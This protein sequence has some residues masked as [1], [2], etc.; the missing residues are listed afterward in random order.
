MVSRKIVFKIKRFLPKKVFDFLLL[1]KHVPKNIGSA[2]LEL[3]YRFLNRFF[4][5]YGLSKRERKTKIILSTTTFPKRINKEFLSIETILRQTIKP[6]KIILWLAKNEFPHMKE[7]LPKKLLDLEK[8]G[9]TIKFTDNNLRSNNKLFH[10]LKENQDSIIIT[11]DDD[12]FYPKNY[13]EKLFKKH[14]EFPK[15]I[16]GYDAVQIKFDEKGNVKKYDD[17]FDYERDNN[18]RNDTFLLSV[19]GILYP[20]RSISKEAFND[21]VL[22]EISLYN[23]DIWFKAMALLQGTKHRRI[24]KKNKQFPSIL[25]TQKFGLFHSNVGENRNDKIISDVFKR[26]KL[27]KLFR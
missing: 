13:V 18:S 22:R 9:L 26:Y 14:L 11:F 12:C 6:D 7:R 5:T 1:I 10:S 16:I 4:K 17:W 8:R 3:K 21:K 27:S 25:G 20:P 2:Y 23:D 24:F 19:N 15:D